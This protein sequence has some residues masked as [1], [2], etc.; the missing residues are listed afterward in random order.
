MKKVL[1]AEDHSIVIRGMKILFET[2]FNNY[3]LDIVNNTSDLMNY[4]KKN[5]YHLAIVDLQLEDAD[6][7]HLITDIRN[8][9][10]DLHVLIF[11]GNP[12]ELY[13]QK[14]YNQGVKGY[15]SKQATDTEIIYA[16]HQ[17]LEGK[18]YMSENFKK[19]LLRSRDPAH[20]SPFAKLSQREMEVLNLMIQGKRSSE[21]CR[22][23]N[24]QASTVATYKAKL[25]SKL[26]VN[27]VLE[28]KQLVSNY[29]V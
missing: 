8:L 17:L 10:P 14:L 21:I 3:S 15:L 27:N 25:F 7:L 11:S 23:L 13:A 16:L 18:T 2:E 5:V 26:A 22:E 24:L 6:T 12:E 9:Y 28:L 19:F 29:K 4:L 1:F 20:E